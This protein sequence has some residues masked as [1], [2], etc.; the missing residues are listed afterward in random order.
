MTDPE[1]VATPWHLWVVGLFALLFNG[2]G[3]YDYFMSQ[4][5]NREH[6]QAALEMGGMDVTPAM[7]DSAVQYFSEFPFWADLLWAL[8]VWGGVAGALL[9]LSRSRFAYP[10]WLV[11]LFGLVTSNA[12]GFSDPFPG[13]T[14]M[15]PTLIAVTAIFIIMVLLTLYARSLVKQ[16]V[17]R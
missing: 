1:T 4:T 7:V 12:Y 11:S 8:G 3:A 16:G 17:L 15:T 5:G 2:Y 10:A 13:V 6:V 14:D 9:L